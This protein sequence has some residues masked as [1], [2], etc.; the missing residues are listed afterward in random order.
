MGSWNSRE[1]VEL[2]KK[3]FEKA[4]KGSAKLA[5][6]K[7][8]VKKGPGKGA[9]HPVF[10]AV[11]RLRAAYV[12]LG[13]R[14]VMNPISID[15]VQVRKQFGPEAAAVLDRCY[16]LG[17][18]P[19]PNVGVSE[20][21][22]EEIR[23]L[24]VEVEKGALQK[25][26]HGYKKGTFGGDD[27]IYKLAGALGTDDAKAMRVLNE[28][29][30]EFIGLDPEAS[31]TTLRSHMTSGWFLTLESLVPREQLPLRLFSID[32]CFRREQREDES[33]LRTYHSAS[34]VVADGDAGIEDGEEVAR[35]LLSRFGF[36]EVRFEPDEKRSKYYAPGTQTEVYI[37][38][39]DGEWIEI[40]TFG[41]YS[42]VALSGY[43]IEVPVMNL[44][45]GVERLAMLLSGES[46]LRELVM[47][48]FHGEWKL[49]DESIAA[50]LYL[51]RVPASAEGRKI[52]EGIVEVG[53]KHASDVAP[54][55]FEVYSGRLFGRAI[56]VKL[57]EVEEGKRLLG[58][59][60]FNDIYVHDGN[61]T[62]IPPDRGFE[63]IKGRGIRTGVS[64]LSA[65]ANLA[66]HEIEKAVLE[67]EEEVTVRSRIVRS[68]GDV[69]L[70]LDESALR[71]I[72]ANNRVIDVRGPVFMTVGAKIE[73]V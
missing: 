32:R 48:Q 37:K 65:L 57:V 56:D 51:D 36:E 55:S 40:A 49:D 31:K 19:R 12:E 69:N 70:R 21:K 7:G 5:S 45:L 54:C 72:T 43:R 71:Y 34:C 62:G 46:D 61:I 47:P 44:G 13:F 27:L 22:L 53:T 1:M 64:Y 28:V 18:L 20:G 39:K 26:L 66:A 4:W 23:K 25:V 14:E 35:G 24:G 33:H 67:G 8:A 10:E 60:T 29:F 17:G 3:D 15:E 38:G 73:Q 63:E 16:Y 59:A 41:M 30:P 50:M 68:F 2:S 11:Q 52:A 58:P 9:P 6:G 42:P